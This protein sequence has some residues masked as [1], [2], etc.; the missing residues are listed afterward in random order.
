MLLDVLGC[1]RKT[2]VQQASESSLCGSADS[3]LGS[4]LDRGWQSASLCKTVLGIEDC[5][6]SP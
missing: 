1:T 3:P 2:L 5:N 4:S 6:C